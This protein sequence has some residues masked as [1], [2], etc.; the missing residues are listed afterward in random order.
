MF[1]GHDKEVTI[2]DDAG[3]D[4]VIIRPALSSSVKTVIAG[5]ADIYGYAHQVHANEPSVLTLRCTDGS[6]ECGCRFKYITEEI[7]MNYQSLAEALSKAIE[8]E[9]AEKNN[10]FITDEKLPVLE[11]KSYDFP[12]MM[13]EFQTLVRSLMATAANEPKITAIVEKYLGKGKKVSTCTV[14]QVEQLDLI[15]SDLKELVE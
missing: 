5:M 8:R 12:A 11:Q 1:I 3:R 15:L 13:Q 10:E 6:I 14:D 2:K 7:P 9:A 4:R